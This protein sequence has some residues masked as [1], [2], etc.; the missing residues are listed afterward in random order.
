[1]DKGGMKINS[2]KL[3]NSEKK[4]IQHTPPQIA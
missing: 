2:A 1:M 4:L 3:K